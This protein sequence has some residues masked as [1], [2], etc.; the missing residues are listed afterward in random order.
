MTQPKKESA[1]ASEAKGADQNEHV[2]F[3]PNPAVQDT[4]WLSI[5]RGYSVRF[6]GAPGVAMVSATW[7]PRVPRSLPRLVKTRRY[8]AALSAFT[9]L[10]TSE[11]EHD[12]RQH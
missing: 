11:V 3:K 8:K 2:D 5:G 12:A 6:S 7:R 9:A 4:G 10:L 1:Q